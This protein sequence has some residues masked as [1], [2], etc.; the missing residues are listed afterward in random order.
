MPMLLTAA[1]S[2]EREPSNF[3]IYTVLTEM[4]ILSKRWFWLHGTFFL[5]LH[6]NRTGGELIP[7]SFKIT[8]SIQKLHFFKLSNLWVSL[9]IF[10]NWI[11]SKG[12]G[13]SVVEKKGLEMTVFPKVQL[14]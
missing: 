1:F 8:F 9:Q 10:E 14:S 5:H 12:G 2:E 11:G 13:L 6:P 4:A 3:L 7:N